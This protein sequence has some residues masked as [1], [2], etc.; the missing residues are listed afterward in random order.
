MHAIAAL[1]APVVSGGINSLETD[2]FRLQCFQT[3]TGI[4]FFITAQLGTPDLDNALKTIYEL[5]VDYV[6]KNPFYEL[7]MP[8]RC[9]LFN[10]GLKSFVEKFNSDTSRRRPLISE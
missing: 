3:L 9:I 10:T 5:Y 8:I 4:K 1:A 2:T 6:L 7:E